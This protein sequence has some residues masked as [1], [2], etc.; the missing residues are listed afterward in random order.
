[1]SPAVAPAPA[2]IAGSEALGVEAQ[3]S[4]VDYGFILTQQE[5]N[6]L[7]LQDKK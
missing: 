7:K 2:P 5:M 4:L 6:D 1:M 3:S